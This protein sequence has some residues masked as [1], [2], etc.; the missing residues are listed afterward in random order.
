MGIAFLLLE[1]KSIVQ[2]SLLFGTTWINN[3]L[4]FLGVLLLV[5]AANWTA[6]HIKT[7]NML[8]IIYL[9]LILS[10]LVTLLFP[11]SGLLKVEN[12]FL[13]FVIASLMTFS[14]I[15]FANLIFSITFR[16]QELP[17]HI[18]GWN[19]IGA[20]IGGILEYS[21]M[22]LG[23]NMLAVIVAVCYTIVVIMIYFDREN[24]FSEG[25]SHG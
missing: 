20:T 3:S 6:V 17:E 19:L 22:A 7:R 21:S 14:P 5:L 15:Y 12:Y 4:V 11:L 24:L 10:S 1:T 8:W 13:R 9:F 25:V 2:F 23:Y 18:F 16:D